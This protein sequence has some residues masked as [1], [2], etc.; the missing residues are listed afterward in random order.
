MSAPIDF[1][2]SP[3]FDLADPDFHTYGDVDQVFRDLRRTEPVYWQREKDGPG[4]WSITKYDDIVAV[5]KNPKIFSSDLERGGFHIEDSRTFAVNTG[6]NMITSD[7]PQHSAYRKAVAPA[8][9][10]TRVRELA[11]T[12]Q[13]SVAEVMQAL[14]SRSTFDFVDLVSAPV[15]IDVLARLLGASRNKQDLIRWSDE[16]VGY[17]DPTVRSSEAEITESLRRMSMFALGLRLK[18]SK[19]PEDTMISMLVNSKT[20]AGKPMNV[21]DFIATFILLIVA[22][23]E[24]SRNAISGGMLALFENAPQKRLL[25]EHPEL[26]NAAANEIVRWVT[27]VIY[28]RRTATEDVTLR[29]TRIKAGDKVVLWY[30]SGNRDEDTFE[31]PYEFDITRQKAAHLGFGSGTH[32][33]VGSRVARMQIGIL[34]TSL[35]QRYPNIQLAGDVEK[36]RSNFINGVKRMPVS[37]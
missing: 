34:F 24:T 35:L 3:A 12:I 30:T 33:C 8:F 37:V 27:P 15:A 17:D 10:P 6:T 2:Q 28:M 21:S 19:A 26:A 5:S 32:Y 1:A 16:L 25:S 13:N 14:A 18:Y 11:A 29:N 9:A 7:P 36:L 22:G 4:F 31:R 23:N 20:D